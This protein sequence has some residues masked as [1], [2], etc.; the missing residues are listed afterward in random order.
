MGPKRKKVV[1]KVESSSSEYEEEVQERSKFP[2]WSKVEIA[3]LRVL[4]GQSRVLLEKR[5]GQVRQQEIT[6]LALALGRTRE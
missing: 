6:R 5:R 1:V 2:K 4:V 3:K